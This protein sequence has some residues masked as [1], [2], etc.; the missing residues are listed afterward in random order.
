L[1]YNNYSFHLPD[2]GVLII[3]YWVIVKFYT[4]QEEGMAKERWMCHEFTHILYFM[5]T[6]CYNGSSELAVDL[7]H[8]MLNSTLA[9]Q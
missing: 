2:L 5:V 1:I 8:I 4:I 3:L 9:T 6:E 7:E